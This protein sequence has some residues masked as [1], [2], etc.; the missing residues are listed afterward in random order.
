M[1]LA[2]VAFVGVERLNSMRFAWDEQQ[3]MLRDT[4]QRFV[5]DKNDFETRRARIARGAAPELWNDLAELGILAVPFAEADGGL[6]GGALE[7]AIVMEA[8]G[9]GL[10]VEPYLP[11]ILLGGGVLRLAGTPEQRDTWTAPLVAGE[12]RFAFGF[13]EPRSRYNLAQVTTQVAQRGKGY[14]VNGAKSVVLGAPHADHCFV[15]ARTSGEAGAEDGISILL[16]PLAAPGVTLRPYLCMDGMPAAELTLSDVEVGPEALFGDVGKGHAIA[17][18]VIDEATVAIC[19]EAVGCVTA[20]N[21]KCLEYAQTRKAFGQ[22]IADFQA[23]QHRLVDMRL[24]AEMASAITLKAAASLDSGSKDAARAVA[25]CKA[26]VGEEAM[27]IAKAAVQLHGAIGT[28]EE[29][30]IGHYFR[31][32]TAIQATFG[33]ADHHTQRYIELRRAEAGE[34]A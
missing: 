21:Q 14:V 20:L 22:P 8:F 11:S 30:D 25:A 5:A 9:R 19:A 1:A 26:Q 33:N 10:M 3:A 23:I 2:Q 27:F 16:V 6:G 17:A 34:E 29:L 4:V 13:A 7:I 12:T 15:T 32:I 24:A 28:T 18:R 31:R